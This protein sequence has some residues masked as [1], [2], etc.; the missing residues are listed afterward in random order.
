MNDPRLEAKRAEI[1]NLLAGL[2]IGAPYAS[3]DAI[4]FLLFEALEQYSDSPTMD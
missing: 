3:V 4:K 2:R 1:I